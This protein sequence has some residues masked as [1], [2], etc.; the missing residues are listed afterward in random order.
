MLEFVLD[1]IFCMYY[2]IIFISI[3]RL[4]LYIFLYFI[5]EEIRF[6][7]WCRCL[8]FRFRFNLC[9]FNVLGRG[10]VGIW[11]VYIFL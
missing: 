5:D 9:F 6:G 3:R 10:I 2:F 8:G 7:E 4:I 1:S 11:E